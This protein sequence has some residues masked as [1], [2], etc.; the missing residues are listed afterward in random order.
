MTVNK[1][2]S[3]PNRVVAYAS[4]IVAAYFLISGLIQAQS[5]LAPVVLALVIA[6][7]TVPLARMMENKLNFP[8]ILASLVSLLVVIFVT[9]GITVLVFFQF[10]NF[11]ADSG[12]ITG[13]M[14]KTL[15]SVEEFMIKNTPLERESLD[16]FKADYGLEESE[17]GAEEDNVKENQQEAMTI[18]AAMGGFLAAW[19][20]TYV[21]VFLFIQYR[22]KFFNFL[23]RLFPDDQR[24]RISVIVSQSLDVVQ[25]YIVGRLILMVF[26]A[27]LYGIGLVIS[28]VENYVLVSLIGAV[29]S[30]I[31]F[32]GNMMA[33]VIAVVI[34]LGGG[35][36]S[37]MILGV[38]ITFL[39]VQFADSYVF[40]PLVLG[41]K[42]N[43]NPFFIIISV[44][45]GN[46]IWGIVGM[47]LSIPLF[48]VVTIITNKV[49]AGDAFGYLFRNSKED[50]D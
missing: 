16:E 10:S 12:D 7:L 25:H 3:N 50:V 24:K 32:I 44:L 19:I 14:E 17:A 4:V 38:T 20:L 43:V 22:K 46:A 42:L 31:P 1:L 33:Y 35:G 21:Y 40:Q 8:K 48:A 45:V 27:V 34:G 2:F 37:Q 18:L 5:V 26:L 13:K 9:V 6:M 15:S 29:L 11:I 23:L 39:I 28:G 30:I 47:V 36:D 41:N 49:P